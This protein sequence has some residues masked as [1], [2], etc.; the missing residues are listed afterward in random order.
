VPARIASLDRA[1][2]PG[3]LDRFKTLL[4]SYDFQNPPDPKDVQAV[5]AWV[6]RGGSL[7]LVGGSDQ[8]G[9][10]DGAWWRAAGSRSPLEAT[11]KQLGVTLREPPHAVRAA[12]EDLSRFATATRT[13]AHGPASR[14]D[15][16]V[17]LTPYVKSTGSV[18]VRF[19]AAQ[20]DGAGGP[21]LYSAELRVG[22]QIVAAFRSGSD[23]EN[24]FITLDDG[25]QCNGEARFVSGHGSWIY[26]FDNL[27][28]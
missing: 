11:W 19:S 8:D 27:P 3:Y 20:P 9:A 25:S 14:K 13:D 28:K 10:V 21:Y 7:V 6:K 23:V 5:A 22:S 12:S 24:R 2:D 26:Q 15:Y 1:A 4:L 17:D 16:T 18:A